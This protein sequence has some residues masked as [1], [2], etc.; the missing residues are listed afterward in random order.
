MLAVFVDV[1]PLL[2]QTTV[3]EVASAPYLRGL[4]SVAVAVTPVTTPGAA[5]Y[6][7]NECV[8]GIAYF[9]GLEVSL[10]PEAGGEGCYLVPIP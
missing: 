6:F 8:T 1:N 10:L 2:G 3:A 7:Y 9:I 4:M 5:S